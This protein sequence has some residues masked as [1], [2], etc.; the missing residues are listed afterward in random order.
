MVSDKKK[1]NH[2]IYYENNK[3]R[4]KQ[5]REKNKEKIK[6]YYIKNKERIIQRTKKYSVDNKERNLIKRREYKK[7]KKAT[8]PL[9]KLTSSISTSINGYISR[10]GYTKKS[11]THQILGCSY[12]EFKQHLENQF[13]PWMNWE[14]H[15][16]YN[17]EFN[18]GWDIDHITPISS[19]TTEAEVLQLSHYT[20]FQPLCSKVNRYIKRDN[21]QYFY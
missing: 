21:H 18:Y 12:I 2:K 1:L 14:N 19:A 7:R 20:N 9:Y 10:G 6:E 4:N 17:G 3:E 13:E 11:R 15:G 5:W 8:D 16:K